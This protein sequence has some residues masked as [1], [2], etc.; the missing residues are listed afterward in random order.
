MS[1]MNV[2]QSLPAGKVGKRRNAKTTN[3][4]TEIR[5]GPSVATSKVARTGYAGELSSKVQ[6]LAEVSLAEIPR[7]V[8]A[9]KN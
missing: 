4:I 2:V 1:A 5:L 8:Q 6:T 9:I 7:I 3:T